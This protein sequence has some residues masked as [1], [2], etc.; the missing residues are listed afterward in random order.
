MLW[1]IDEN[2][3]RPTWAEINLDALAANFRELRRGA[4]AGVMVMAVVKANAYGHGAIPCARRLA[5][6]GAD[7]FAVAL[8]EEG[9]ALREAGIAQPILV[10]GGFWAEQAP[11]CVKYDLVPV[12]YRL[13]VARK[14]DCAARDAG[15]VVRAHIKIDTGMNRLGVRADEVGEFADAMRVLQHIRVE[16]LLTHF[17]AADEPE[18]NEFTA[19]QSARFHEARM[20]FERRGFELKYK[21]LANSAGALAHRESR[22]NIVRPGGVLY[23]LWRDVLPPPLGEPPN[24]DPVMA[25]RTRVTLLK[26]VPA[27]ETLGYGR[28]FKASRETL[29]ATLPIGYH[30]GY[31]RSLS[32]VGRVIVRGHYAPVVGRVSMDMTLVD[33]TD[34][35][36]ASADD[37]VTLIGRDKDLF[38]AAEEVAQT[39][40]TISYEI[41][42]GISDRVDRYYRPLWKDEG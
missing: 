33:V 35:P 20:V 30:D 11:L 25:L 16:G 6:E 23:G 29:V 24:L 2:E 7:W 12:I 18:Q 28:T 15:V 38:I 13:D 31:P 17:A 40:G 41:T 3:R 5:L 37:V 19:D 34:V 26:R 22:G 32:N 1:R 8:P 21:Y 9:I 39:A 10:L 27:G 4:G 14:L 36:G 42:C